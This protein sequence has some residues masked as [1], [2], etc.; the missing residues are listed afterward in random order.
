MSSTK[1]PITVRTKDD[2][3]KNK[4]LHLSD[5]HGRSLS[6]ECE[7]ILKRYVQS[8]EETYG[9]IKLNK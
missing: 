9:E 4:L 8:Y 3:L 2:I 7:L 6:K 1:T 5:I